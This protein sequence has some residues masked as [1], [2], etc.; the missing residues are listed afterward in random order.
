MLA[1]RA[2]REPQ[3]LWTAASG[4]NQSVSRQAFLDSGGFH[5][6]LTINEHRELALRLCQ[7]GLSMAA[8]TGRTFHLIHRSGWRDPLVEADWEK[9]FY[10]THPTPEVALMSVLWA[11]L[12]DRVAFPD[13]A[14]ILD[15][16][17]LARAAQRCRGVVGA[18]AVRAAH[19]AHAA[20]RNA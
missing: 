4:S 6:A 12:S 20:G 14:R 2:G 3:L 15:L 16:E 11:S 19:F 5:P 13:A 10:A 9:T 1:L 17:S 7:A 8:T 18:D